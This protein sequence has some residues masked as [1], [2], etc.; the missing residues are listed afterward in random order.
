MIEAGS[1]LIGEFKYFFNF[2]GKGRV[3]IDLNFRAE[4]DKALNFCAHSVVIEIEVTQDVD[5]DPL[6]KLK[7]AEKDVFGS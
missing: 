6:A 1:F 4:T 5:R 2:P 7:Q 3:S